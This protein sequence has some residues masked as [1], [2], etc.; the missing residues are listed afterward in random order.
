LAEALHLPVVAEY[1]HQ[2]I[3]MNEHQKRRFAEKI[4]SSMF[5]TIN[6]KHIA[7]LGWAFKKDTGDT[8]ES[9]AITIAESLLLEGAQ[10][11]VYDPKVS[12][13]R[14]MLDLTELGTLGDEKTGK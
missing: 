4:V 10:L 12:S 3:V 14:M 6:G 5:N 13:I 2:V 1:W 8:R 11:N 9:A 7:V